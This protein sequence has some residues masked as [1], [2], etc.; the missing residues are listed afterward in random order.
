MLSFFD[1]INGER[2]RGYKA[3][4]SD[5]PKYEKFAREYL[6]EKK[7]DYSG[8]LI[9]YSKKLND[10]KT[11]PKTAGWRI[12]VVKEFLSRN[13][14]VLDSLALK[15][16]R[17]LKPKGGR[18]TNFEYIDKK[19]IGEILPHVKARGKA[20]ILVMASSGC[21]IGEVLNIHWDDIKTPDRNKYPNKPTSV[22]I[23]TSKTGHTRTTYISREA[24]DAI[25]AW[26]LEYPK[27]VDGATKR[28]ENLKSPGRIKIP[29]AELLFPF[30]KSAAYM[31]WD[32]ALK[33]AGKYNQDSGTRRLQMNLHRLRNFFSVQVSAI[34]PQVAELLLG[35]TDQYGGAYARRSQE[36]MEE[37][38]VRA[39]FGLTIGASSAQVEATNREVSELRK[40]L[41]AMKDDMADYKKT[42]LISMM[43]DR[44]YTGEDGKTHIKPAY[45]RLEILK[46]LDVEIPE[47]IPPTTPDEI[48][49]YEDIKEWEG[50]IPAGELEL[51]RKLKKTL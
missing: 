11:P 46:M 30:T 12:V 43:G 19:T 13:G 1:F 21:R 47:P 20:F 32:G 5:L 29:R 42:A 14:I 4:Q 23:R 33:M 16:V 35:H 6:L 18:R 31:M 22:F 40:Q 37:I 28:S 44:L 39:E 15:D 8:D 3:V 38:Y 25:E 41:N 9:R 26:K 34:N 2:I 7:R 50:E 27:Y 17:R 45:T 36:E 24:E 49:E 48:E 51:Y 10:E